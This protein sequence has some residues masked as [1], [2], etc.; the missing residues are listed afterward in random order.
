MKNLKEVSTI[1][2][3]EKSIISE[4]QLDSIKGGTVGNVDMDGI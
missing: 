4:D 1:K 3:L 2:N